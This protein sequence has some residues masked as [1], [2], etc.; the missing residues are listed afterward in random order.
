MVCCRAYLIK[1]IEAIVLWEL[2]VLPQWAPPTSGARS[3][4]DSTLLVACIQDTATIVGSTS[5]PAPPQIYAFLD[6]PAVGRSWHQ[7]FNLLDTVRPQTVLL[8]EAEGVLS[9]KT[10]ASH[11]EI[12]TRIPQSAI[13]NQGHF[14]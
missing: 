7:I 5:S 4:V 14:E 8:L 12:T 13:P 1:T 2:D 3:A 6:A 9:A 11:R 10:M